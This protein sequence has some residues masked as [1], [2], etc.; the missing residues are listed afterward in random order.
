MISAI[1]IIS[2]VFKALLDSVGW[3]LA[4]VYDVVPNYGVAI[5]VL[6]MVI[7]VGLL[8]LFL[9]QMKSMQAM[10][11]IQPKIKEIQK[12]YKG[13]RQKAQEETMKL[14]QEH[15]VNPLAS[16]LPMLLQFPVLI[17]VYSVIRAPAYEPVNA[18]LQPVTDQAEIVSYEVVDN[19][20]PFDSELFKA[21]V[22]H[23][24]TSLVVNLQCG[25]LQAGNPDASRVNDTTGKPV[26]EGRPLL[27]D[28][29]QPVDSLTAEPTLACGSSWPAKIPYAA[30]LVIM[31]GT[32]YFQQRQMQRMA[33]PGSAS[34]QQQTLMKVMPL[35]FA[36]F[37]IQFPAGLVLY[38]TFSNVVQ[39]TQ[40]HFLMRAGHIG[41]VAMERRIAEQQAKAATPSGDRPAARKGIFG[42]M[43]ERAEQERRRRE[44]D[45][46]K[47]ETTQ[48]KPSG[49][50]G[51]SGKSGTGDGSGSGT[52]TTGTTGGTGTSKNNRSGGTR[53]PQQGR[54]KKRRR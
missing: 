27:T 54:R 21:I 18:E 33:P 11:S 52:G 38:W 47:R 30:L 2:P 5:L 29:G 26:I 44:Q 43:M 20:I 24:G 22:T 45:L 19:H 3:V 10:Q 37:G 49:G 42:R 6:T 46:I 15:G 23:E 51:S 4:R 53:R 34:Q 41:P 13:N 7:R 17:A 48:R 9:K 14:Y 31:V 1:P 25:V 36:V 40:Q 35:M 50:K 39:I 8:P 16:C 12:K 32:T 28:Q